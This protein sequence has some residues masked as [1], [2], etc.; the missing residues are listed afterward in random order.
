MSKEK[1]KL[2]RLET[3]KP[4][5]GT[6]LFIVESEVVTVMMMI[7]MMM[8]MKK[9]VFWY[10]TPRRCVEGHIF[11]IKKLLPPSS[12][13]IEDKRIHPDDGKTGE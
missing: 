2:R 10:T 12:R 8:M 9:A 4:R 6:E 7:M 11:F 5:H 1:C 13:H 3:E